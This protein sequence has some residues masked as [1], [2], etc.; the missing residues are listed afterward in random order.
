MQIKKEKEGV[1]IMKY[2]F[3]RSSTFIL[4]LIISLFAGTVGHMKLINFDVLKSV[5]ALLALSVVMV[6]VQLPALIEY[7]I[8]KNQEGKR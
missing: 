8:R 7:V 3:W 2:N 4:L 5:F 1:N 6:I